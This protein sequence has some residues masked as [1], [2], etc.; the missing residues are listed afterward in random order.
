M[1]AARI[2]GASW[3]VGPMSSLFAYCAGPAAHLAVTPPPPAARAPRLSP[4]ARQ[5]ALARLRLARGELPEALAAFDAA[6]L[7]DPRF[8]LAHL[9]RAVC[10]TEMGLETEARA[11]LFETLAAARGQEEAL[12]TLARMCALQGHV[13][14]AMP[15]LGAAVRARPQDTARWAADR[16]F[17]DHPA[18][19]QVLGAL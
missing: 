10:L 13:A 6:L 19:L 5:L 12:Y 11:A 16:A 14:L 2:M 15:L 3:H 18:Y 9:G 1:R 8:A 4:F 17:A 7:H